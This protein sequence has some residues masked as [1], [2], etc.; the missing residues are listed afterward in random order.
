MMTDRKLRGSIF[1]ATILL[2]SGTVLLQDS[3]PERARATIGL[4]CFLAII[5][6]CSSN[7]RAIRWRTVWCGLG[8]QLALAL[9]ILR[10]EVFGF[11]PGYAF[12]SGLA[13]VVTGFLEFTRAGSEFVFGVLANQN[14]MEQVFPNGLVLAFTALPT[15]IFVSAFFT[16]LYYLGVIQVLVALMARMMAPLM[17]T[18]GAETLSAVANVFMGQ[19][20]APIMVKPYI[21]SMTRSELLALMTGGLATIAGS[22]LVVYI[23]LGADPVAIAQQWQSRIF[24]AHLKD[25]VGTYPDYKHTI[26]GQGDIDYP[27]I[28][29]GLQDIGFAEAISIETFTTQDFDESCEVG[30][31]ALAPSIGKGA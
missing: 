16:V 4:V 23:S 5:V 15:I 21:P 7:I 17:R 30:Y 2:A 8:L 31:K 6:A 13:A 9:L 11:R 1:A 29:K 18:S 22:V 10:F 3:L 19:T 20:E 12:F 26:P 14:E 24:H 25:H 28:V 27:R